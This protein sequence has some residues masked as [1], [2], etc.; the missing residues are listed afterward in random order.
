MQDKPNYIVI[1]SAVS[2]PYGNASDNAIYTFMDGFQE[3]GCRGEVICL[4]P[5]SP[6]N[7]KEVLAEGDYQGV[8]YSYLPGYTTI[9]KSKYRHLVDFWISP[10]RNLKK[11]LRDLSEKYQVV[12][13]FVAYLDLRIYRYTKICKSLGISTVMV[14]CEYPIF[15]NKSNG[16][17][18]FLYRHYSK[19]IDKYVFETKT[20]K[21]FEENALGKEVNAIVIPATMP[22][23]DIL[24]APKQPTEPYI[25]YSGSVHSENKDGLINIIKAFGQFHVTYPEVKLMF[26]GRIA[27]RA[28]YDQLNRLVEELDLKNYVSF[29]KEVSRQDYIHYMTNAEMMIVAKPKD[30][31]Y[32]GGLS[33]KVIE[34]LFSGNPVVMVAADDYVHYLTH[35]ENVYFTDD[36]KPET[37]FSALFEMHKNEDLRKQIGISGKEFAISNFNYHFLTKQIMDF[38]LN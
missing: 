23:E 27:N 21:D 11:H 37:L 1:I 8:K 24:N 14:T 28:Y 5:N 34:Y 13:M 38:I 25:A 31:Y 2:F 35:K 32:G 19:N 22:F 3:H 9:P 17:K 7:H 26:I 33:S 30:S 12:A 10:E 16:Y 15:L 36:N 18:R 6:S 29:T 4:Y 20:L